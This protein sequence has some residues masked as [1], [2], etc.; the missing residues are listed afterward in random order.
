MPLAFPAALLPLALLPSL[1]PPATATDADFDPATAFIPPKA[2]SYAP[3]LL[4]YGS[5]VRVTLAES[6]GRTTVGVELTGVAPGTEFPA[7]VHTG[8]CGADPAAAGPHY[9]HWADPV[10]PSTD[11][12]YANDRN[13][14]RLTVRTDGS[15]S[16]S[17]RSTVV[18][19]FRPGEARS[20]VLHTARAAGK[21]A[22]GDRVG[23]VDVEF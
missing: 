14:V 15:G 8:T 18:W 12:A 21:H 9:Q 11:P 17:A 2:I 1:V 7:H 3:D 6:P 13:E 5:H 19:R 4:P 20:V 10:Q 16:G 23:C 22:A